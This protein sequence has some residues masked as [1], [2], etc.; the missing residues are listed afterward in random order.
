[1]IRID[2]STTHDREL[3]LSPASQNGI[4][5]RLGH[6]AVSRMQWFA[7]RLAANSA[8]CALIGFGI[9][10]AVGSASTHRSFAID[11]GKHGVPGWIAGPLD[12]YGRPMTAARFILLFGAMWAAYLVVLAF[13]DAVRLR[14]AVA[15]IVGLHV[16]FALAP[17]LLSTDVF[18]YIDYSRLGVVHHLN[19]YIHG[20]IA[21]RHDPV[22]PFVGWRQT[23]SIYG[24]LFTLMSY[25]LV[26][27][28]VVK[29]L[30]S[31]KILT[32][33]ASLGCVALVWRCAVRRGFAPLPA[34]LFFGLNPVLLVSAV[35]GAHN[36]VL[37]LL[38]LMGAIA[39]AL[40]RREALGGAALA[41]AVAI[42]ATAAPLVPFMLLGARRR[43]AALGG[44]LVV[45]VGMAALT[46]AVFGGQVHEFLT[47]LGKHQRLYLDQ[48]VAPHLGVLIGLDPRS[49]LLR[50]AA[51]ALALIVVAVMLVRT[52]RGAD[53]LASA[54]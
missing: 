32:A 46:F 2:G 21:A 50:Q 51:E 26:P 27:L 14:W 47:I 54:G 45:A 41:G 53:W 43:G 19:P 10:I 28:G 6:P 29:E 13:S 52:W 37:A 12:F 11:N 20:P 39:L 30:W 22:Y 17:P 5:L 18:N 16:V 34:A 33:L 49:Q 38:L 36:D 8:L 23:P 40:E 7:R 35:G 3:P 48:S 4:A 42:K 44:M 31:L 1:M 15:S 9:A 25:A 24:P